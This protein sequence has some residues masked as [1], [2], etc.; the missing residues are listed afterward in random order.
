MS[1]ILTRNPVI[2]LEYSQK[3]KAVPK[4][5]L[6]DYEKGAIYVVSAHDKSVIFDITD[7]IYEQLKNMSGDNIEITIEGIGNVKLTDI[8]KQLHQDILDS[9]KVVNIGSDINYVARENVLDDKSLSIVNRNIEMK[10]FSAAGKHMIPR[11]GEDGNLEWIDM[12]MLPDISGGGGPGIIPPG[13]PDNGQI[14][15]VFVIEP[16]NDKLYLRATRRQKSVNLDRN[17]KVIIPRILDEFSEIEWYVVTNSFC[18]MLKFGSNVIWSNILETQP[19]AN[20]HQIYKFK[21]WDAGETWLAELVPYGKTAN[22]N[23][24]DMEYLETNYFNKNQIQNNYYDKTEVDEKISAINTLNPDDYYNKTEMKNL[25]YDKRQVDEKI[26]E[27]EKGN[28]DL[29]NYYNKQEIDNKFTELPKP[30]M[31]EYVTN[32]KLTQDYYN[33]TE[34]DEKVTQIPQPDMSEYVTNDKLAQDHYNKTEVDNK[35]DAIE[36]L[37][38]EHYYNKDQIHESY[39]NK[40][41]IAEKYYDKKYIDSEHYNKQETNDLISWKKD[42]ESKVIVDK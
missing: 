9:V 40:D 12:P 16:V 33:K 31:S 42:Q 32:D 30:D 15:E 11:K 34:V 20:A 2:A 19:Q 23:L 18:P 3:H 22:T 26:D 28:V 37:N 13:N 7:K 5:L 29:S 10:G 25:Y 6:I 38:P 17:C 27:I 1:K 36:G 41:E 39:L 8:L 14:T 24:V 21:T 35:I 4:E